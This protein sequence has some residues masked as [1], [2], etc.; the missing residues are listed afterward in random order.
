MMVPDS[1]RPVVVIGAGPAGLTAALQLA[2]LG[3][4]VSVIEAGPRVGGLAQ[5]VE[6]KGYRFDLGGHRFFTKV[7]AVRDLWR[8]MLGADFLKRPRL[9]RIFF[10]G[11]FFEYPLKPLDTLRKLGLL[12]S[13]AILASYLLVKLRPVHPEVSFE[14]WVT[15]RFGRRLFR[16]FFEAYTEKVWGIPCRTISAR[17]AAQRIQGLSLRTAVMNM[18]APRFTQRRKQVK[19]LIEEFEYPRR[20]PGMMWEAFA[21]RIEQL[22]GTVQLDARVTRLIHDGTTVAAVEIERAGRRIPQPASSVISTMPLT[23]LVAS[24][25]DAIPEPAREAAKR[26]KYRD[27]ITVALIVDRA[28]VF[29]DNW[30]YIHDPAVKV[31][32]IQNFK[33]WSPEMVPDQSTTCLGFEYF[34]TKGDELWSMS[35]DKLVELATKE[36]GVIGLVEPGLVVDGTVVR[37]PKAY[38]VYDEEYARALVD[39]RGCLEQFPNLQSVGRNGTHTY[40]NQDHSMVM[41]MLAVRN[42]FGERNDLWSVESEDEYL[43]ELS[44]DKEP[45]VEQAR[46]QLASTQRLYPTL[47]SRP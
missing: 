20:G 45:S 8:S 6:Y 9:S 32:R 31:G 4:P 11:R 23:H 25:G 19:T 47:V 44:E 17:W 37:V 29:P 43:E 10:D 39:V 16:T 36:L 22:G 33:N 2:E 12:R 46:G 38:P 14:D 42:L 34:C 35:D 41:A 5:T 27:F 30:I 26:L 1:K 3:V 21:A 18:V 28:E 24:L 15:N 40:N 13:V 7:P